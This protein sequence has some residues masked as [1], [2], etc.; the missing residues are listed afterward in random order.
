VRTSP[1]RRRALALVA[2][3]AL[4]SGC[5]GPGAASG[6][7]G[8]STGSGRP[9]AWSSTPPATPHSKAPRPREPR[10]S[11]T[12]P[13]LPPG[14]PGLTAPS[15]PD[16]G[17]AAATPEQER[18]R[19]TVPGSALLD[20]ETVSMALGGTWQRHAGGADEC[21]RPEGALGERTMSFGGT[22]AGVVVETVATYRDAAAAD[23]AVNALAEA[24]AGCGWEARPDPRLGSASVAAED[25]ARALVG[26]SAEGVVV[27]LVASGE[28]T[29]DAA[30]W[31]SLVDLA[32][33]TSC[34]AAPDGCH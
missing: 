10:A 11:A 22:D 30:R 28:V 6:P 14:D 34:P 1:S 31:G 23:R 24:G 20:A 21:V 9:A 32:L 5:G 17:T 13:S 16:P 33:G 3:V 19:R 2:A 25:G 18:A 12:R 8:S 29:K 7:G 15:V 4:L 26:V 27:L